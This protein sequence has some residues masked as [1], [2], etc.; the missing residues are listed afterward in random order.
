M[1]RKTREGLIN[2]QKKEGRETETTISEWLHEGAKY[3]YSVASC[4]MKMRKF[5]EAAEYLYQSASMYRG[6]G[7]I[8]KS[9]EILNLLKFLLS[10]HDIGLQNQFLQEIDKLRK[11]TS[12]SLRSREFI[13]IYISCPNCHTEHQIRASLATIVIKKCFKCQ[14]K[15]SIFYDDDAQE[16]YTNFLEKPKVKP[17]NHMIRMEND[18]VKFCARCGLNVGIIAKFCMRC[19][20]RILKE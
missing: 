17:L 8:E 6:L 18:K 13:Y 14:T 19:G 9:E 11:Q 1:T 12:K 7:F 16:F 5:K 20:L 10:K 3:S 15:F 2:F 4:Y